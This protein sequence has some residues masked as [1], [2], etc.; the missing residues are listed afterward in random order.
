MQA[1]CM[2]GMWNDRINVA[3][4]IISGEFS[5][6]DTFRLYEKERDGMSEQKVIIGNSLDVLKTME[7]GSV[8][9]VI[10]SPPYYL[11]RDYGEQCYSY[12]GGNSYCDH[13][14]NENNICT[15]CGCWY[16]QLGLEKHPMDYINHLMMIF[17]EVKR[18][19]KSTGQCFV[20]IGDSYYSNIPNND[21][22]YCSTSKKQQI[23]NRPHLDG[24]IRTSLL[25]I[26]SRFSIAMTDQGWILR[27]EIIWH[28][29]NPMPV[30][31][32]NRFTVDF[33]K[34][35]FFTKSKK[36]YFKQQVEKTVYSKE[37]ALRNM[38]TTWS[39]PVGCDGNKSGHSQQY[40]LKLVE[41]P[42]NACCPDGGTVL[43]IFQGGG[44]TLRYCRMNNINQIGIEINPEFKEQIES[45]QM[46][47]VGTLDVY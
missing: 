7:P 43:D 30:Q 4:R 46:I 27:N 31:V 40:P 35:F 38:R 2:L 19:L 3:M 11:C 21:Y 5:I 44:T 34:M 41:I 9:M 23:R 26:P 8:D 17:N 18:V 1:E 14:F 22:R 25:Q 24:F 33:E 20:N 15:K 36:Y 10:T 13:V 6:A 16:G 42:I 39:I 32:A 28:K 12:Y 29:P 45:R 47:N 37:Y